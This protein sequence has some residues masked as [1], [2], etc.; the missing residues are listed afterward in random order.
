MHLAGDGREGADHSPQ[1]PGGVGSESDQ[2]A[3]LEGRVGAVA[4]ATVPRRVADDLVVSHS[5]RHPGV[6]REVLLRV[7]G[8]RHPGAGQRSVLRRGPGGV[9][10]AD[11]VDVLGLRASSGRRLG[12]L[13]RQEAVGGDLDRVVGRDELVAVAAV[14]PRRGREEGGD[15]LAAVAKAV[16]ECVGHQIVEQ[17]GSAVL[18]RDGD[19]GDRVGGDLAPVEPRVELAADYLGDEAVA[20]EAAPRVPSGQRRVRRSGHDVAGGEVTEGLLSE[21][22]DL[23]QVLVE[24]RPRT[25]GHGFTLGGRP[26]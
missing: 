6:R 26:P 14:D 16:V 24:E 19:A 17:A 5:E 3:D 4:G 9:D 1:R 15:D 18:G 2:V 23:R 7:G 25:S 21:G 8:E 20:L 10:A 11:V 12:G 13:D 22:Q